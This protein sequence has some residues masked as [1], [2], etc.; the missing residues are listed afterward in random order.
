MI[1]QSTERSLTDKNFEKDNESK[2]ENNKKTPVMRGHR[3][4]WNFGDEFIP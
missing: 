1:P 3:E 4:G 2:I